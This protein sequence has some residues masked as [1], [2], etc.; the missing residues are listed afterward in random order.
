[1]MV[2]LPLR[3]I[4]V[5]LRIFLEGALFLGYTNLVYFSSLGWEVVNKNGRRFGF[6]Y[7]E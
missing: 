6:P 5:P 4:L 1:M 3:K 7:V 2:S